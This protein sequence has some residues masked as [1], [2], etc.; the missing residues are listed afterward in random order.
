M[1]LCL[2]RDLFESFFLYQDLLSKEFEWMAAKYGF[3][4]VDANRMPEQ[5]HADV[6]RLVG[7]LYGSPTRRR[8][9]IA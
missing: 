4:N 6:Q 3:Q 8:A 1:D 7:P 5:V 2:S 9:H